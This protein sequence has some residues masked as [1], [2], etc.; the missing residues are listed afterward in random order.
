M[1]NRLALVVAAATLA[2]VTACSGSG[3]GGSTA[4]GTAAGGS[5]GTSAASNGSAGSS[6]ASAD[7]SGSSAASNGATTTTP[8][9]RPSD[10]PQQD[11]QAKITACAQQGKSVKVTATVKNTSEA[12][13]SYV[14]ATVLKAG[15][16]NV[17]GGP[18]L[19]PS[20]KPGATAT[21]S[22]TIPTTA[23]KVTCE[24]AKV[25]AVAG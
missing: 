17:G 5:A 18:L 21:V 24:I 7:A 11:A 1:R 25:N 14:I 19:A 22:S 20:V 23:Q 12:P 6:G 8:A 15:G 10:Q 4:G 9:Q 16:K 3:S 13:K 2:T